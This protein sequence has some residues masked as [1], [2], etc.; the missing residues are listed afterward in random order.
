MSFLARTKTMLASLILRQRVL[1]RWVHKHL[2]TKRLAACVL[3]FDEE[4]RLLILRTTYRQGWVLPGGIVERNESPWIGAAREVK[5]EIGLDVNNLRFAA[6]DWRSTDDEYDDSLHF[7]FLGGRLTP[8]QQA[9]IQPDGFEIAEHRF[10]MI[11][12]AEALLEHHLLR[13]S[14]PFLKPAE[15]ADRPLILNRGERDEL[16]S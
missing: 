15:T 9:A 2:P 7:V 8:E 13:R 1:N 14:R 6:M 3:F 4:D 16:A 5:E 11:D 12:E 10:A